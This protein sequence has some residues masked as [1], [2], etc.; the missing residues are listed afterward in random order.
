MKMRPTLAAF[1]LAV[2]AHLSAPP[3]VRACLNGVELE[4]EERAML[5]SS[6][7]AKLQGGNFGAAAQQVLTKY[8]NIRSLSL[9]PRSQDHLQARALRIFALAIVRSGGKAS[10][11]EAQA[12]A[13]SGNLEWAVATL[14]ELVVWKQL[15]TVGNA[16]ARRT[17]PAESPDLMADLGEALAAL[18][19][20]RAE[21]KRILADLARRDLLGSAYAYRALARLLSDEGE[22]AA[23]SAALEKCKVRTR[24]SDLCRLS[25]TTKS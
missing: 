20:T 17:A 2:A 24:R 21:G 8:G 9:A 25:P 7:D 13:P 22:A 15:Q 5:L 11:G 14:R 16:L 6:A 19:H 12:W 10:F 23:T 1:A 18:S 3:A 4:T